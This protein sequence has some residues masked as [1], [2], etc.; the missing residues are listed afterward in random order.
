MGKAKIDVQ[1]S[2][3]KDGS[4]YEMDF[5]TEEDS[6]E[7]EDAMDALLKCVLDRNSPKRGAFIPQE[8]GSLLRIQV[9]DLTALKT[10]TPSQQDNNRV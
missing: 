2:Y 1:I 6:K 10:S 7:M 5:R 9:A 3:Q 8:V 4:F